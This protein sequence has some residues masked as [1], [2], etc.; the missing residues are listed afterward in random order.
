M[1]ENYELN[2]VLQM[3]VNAAFNAGS[4]DPVAFMGKFLTE[5]KDLVPHVEKVTIQASTIH[6]E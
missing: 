3:A 6:H 5:R 1:V 2:N 4:T